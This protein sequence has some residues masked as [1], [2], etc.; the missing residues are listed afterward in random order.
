MKSKLLTRKTIIDKILLGINNQDR[1]L[2]RGKGGSLNEMIEPLIKYIEK[3]T[4]I[5]VK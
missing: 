1:V 2:T 4:D 5:E 3:N